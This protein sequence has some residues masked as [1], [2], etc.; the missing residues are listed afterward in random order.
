MKNISFNRYKLKILT[1]LLSCF[2]L[3]AFIPAV[4]A[5]PASADPLM[6]ESPDPLLRQLVETAITYDLYNARCRGYLTA[7]V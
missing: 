2:T 1:L 6:V 7:K 5:L 4:Y 3:C